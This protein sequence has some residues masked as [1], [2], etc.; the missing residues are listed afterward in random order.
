MVDLFSE[1][2]QNNVSGGH[3]L[4]Q[5]GPVDTGLDGL[6]RVEDEHRHRHDQLVLREIV[7]LHFEQQLLGLTLSGHTNFPES[8]L[9]KTSAG[10]NGYL[11]WK[12]YLFS[13]IYL[14]KSLKYTKV[15]KFS[16]KN[17]LN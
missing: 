8:D 5:V 11:N 16:T 12:I 6:V 14:R 9:R 10:C 4:R 7:L 13:V 1:P 2:T 15:A 3:P 17:P